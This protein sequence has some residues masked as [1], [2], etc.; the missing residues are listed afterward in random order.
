MPASDHLATASYFDGRA[1]RARHDS[2]RDRFLLIAEKYRALAKEASD[3]ALD[4]VE[5]DRRADA[6]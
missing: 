6:P 3:R 2:E 4:K 5:K 1:K